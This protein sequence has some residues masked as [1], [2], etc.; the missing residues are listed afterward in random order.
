MQGRGGGAAGPASEQITTRQV[1]TGGP[2]GVWTVWV[3]GRSV[4]PV[5][6]DRACLELGRGAGAMF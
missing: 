4:S 3:V 5:Q 1:L 6:A 2:A